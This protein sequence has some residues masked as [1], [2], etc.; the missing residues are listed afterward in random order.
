MYLGIPF[1]FIRVALRDIYLGIFHVL[2][3]V[4]V[5]EYRTLE[6]EGS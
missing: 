1:P 2:A 4:K 6:F 5:T 3:I